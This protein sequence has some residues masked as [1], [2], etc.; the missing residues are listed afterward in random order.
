MTDQFND[1]MTSFTKANASIEALFS[2]IG[3]VDA[4][5]GALTH[6]KGDALVANVMSLLDVAIEDA[7][8]AF[9][10]AQTIKRGAKGHNIM[11]FAGGVM[12]HQLNLL[13]QF[14]IVWDENRSNP[15]A[16]F[17]ATKMGVIAFD[18]AVPRTA[19]LSNG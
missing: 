5:P 8:R 17:A 19:D 13:K 6:P 1:V 14:R 2:T 7:D 4:Q 18:A 15:V 9:K 11:S 10:Y 16:F 3:A 12:G